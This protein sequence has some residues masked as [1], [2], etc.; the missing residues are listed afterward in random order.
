MFESTS[1]GRGGKA[2]GID[3]TS[4]L[5]LGMRHGS[6]ELDPWEQLTTG[7]PAA[8][9]EAPEAIE[10]ARRVAQLQGCKQGILMPST[11]HLFMDLFGVLA[12]NR[13]SLH[14][15]EGTYA[16]ARWGALRAT[17]DGMA[18]RR[19]PH[20]DP[21]TLM[22]QIRAQL[23]WNKRPVVIADGFCPMCGKPAPIA[24]YL[25]VV[26]GYGGLLVLDDTQALGILGRRPDLAPPY[27]RGGG[28]ILEFSAQAGP[29][30][31]VGSSL[32]KAFGVPVAVLSGGA[33]WI[34]RLK[35]E[36]ETRVHCSPPSLAVIH[37]A[38]R[39]LA[40]NA[41]RG[42]R[43]RM[44]LAERITQ[45]REGLASMGLS[46]TGGFF[47]VQT[48]RGIR[49]NSALQLYQCLRDRGIHTVLSHS[50]EDGEVRLSLLIRACHEAE[51]IARCLNGLND[52]IREI[53]MTTDFHARAHKPDV[54][55]HFRAT[56]A[57]P[58]I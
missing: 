37:A 43:L 20:H 16:I 39:A 12:K 45:W 54:A 33:S 13:I 58:I 35:T 27:G 15:D 53:A 8:L 1:K 3:F 22:A 6:H 21:E 23:R 36:S 5:Y 26:R 51:E 52:S 55:R 28:G 50:R 2:A 34:S 30:I 57:A 49:G 44:R 9:R 4:A 17:A 40:I 10:V 47:P 41:S 25:A 48:M 18:V 19:F 14:M 7:V 11:L 38:A 32:A 46:A 29:D 42:D 31:L 56:R 24:D